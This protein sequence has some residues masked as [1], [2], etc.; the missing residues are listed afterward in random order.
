VGRELLTAIPRDAGATGR[1]IHAAGL[2]LAARIR[3]LHPA[4]ADL[5]V[6]SVWAGPIARTNA[7]VPAI[8]ADASHARLVWA[9]GY[10]GHG[11]AQAFRVGSR[12][13]DAIAG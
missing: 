1:A 6:A 11:L 9:G 10:G 4:F 3:G 7:G 2:R 12:A 5:D 8:A 13:A